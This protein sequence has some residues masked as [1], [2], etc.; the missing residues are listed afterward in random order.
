[1]LAFH[2]WRVSDACVDLTVFRH[3]ALAQILACNKSARVDRNNSIPTALFTR[4]NHPEFNSTTCR[5]GKGTAVLVRLFVDCR[6]ETCFSVS[7]SKRLWKIGKN[8]LQVGF[9]ATEPRNRSSEIYYPNSSRPAQTDNQQLI[10]NLEHRRK[11][12]RACV[13]TCAS[14]PSTRRPVH[15]TKNRQV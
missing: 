11:P 14:C 12:P 15:G 5:R 13:R 6:R 7:R 9:E 3:S 10:S 2:A 8:A 4:E 1:M